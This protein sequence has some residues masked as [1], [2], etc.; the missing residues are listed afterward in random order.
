MHTRTESGINVDLMNNLDKSFTWTPPF[1]LQSDN[2]D[3]DLLANLEDVTL[4]DIDDAFDKLEDELQKEKAAL[5]DQDV[6]G[7]EIL[8]GQIYDFAELAKINAGE[9]SKPANEVIE[10]I[11]S[12]DEDDWDVETMVSGVHI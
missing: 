11:G 1:S 7:G 12:G 9:V 6:D 5:M 8:E 3:D 10:V 4:D 2:D